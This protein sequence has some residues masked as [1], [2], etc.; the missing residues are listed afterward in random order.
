MR[1]IIVVLLGLAFSFW[2][3]DRDGNGETGGPTAP[4]NGPEPGD[5]YV[6][7]YDAEKACVGT[8]L[9]TDG[10]ETGTPKVVEVDMQGEVVWE[11]SLPSDWAEWPIVGFEAELLPTGNILMTLSGS[12]LYEIDRSGNLVWYHEDEKCSHDAD[13]LING[14]TVYIYGAVDTKSDACV[15]EVDAQGNQVWSW[16][17]RDHYDAPPYEDIMYQGWA[18]ANGVSRLAGGNTLISLRNFDLTV[19]VNP[20]GEPVWECDWQNIYPASERPA[21]YPHDPEPHPDGTMLVCLQIESPYE[22]VEIDKNTQ[23]VLW[24]Y[25]RENF[26]TC[27]DANRL[28]NGNVLIVGVLTDLDESVIF[29][30]TPEKEIVWQLRLYRISCVREPGW[31][32]KAQ[33]I[34]Q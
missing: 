11:F 26:R 16:F 20:Q 7:I 9:L 18:H 2:G 33:R 10:H 8:T 28:P 34:V 17:A 14:N 19:E 1:R 22:V 13:R 32:F 21:F 23:E 4:E 15:K 30:V 5:Y 24:E 29:E 27:R 3:C 25:D 6:D 12:G 31:F